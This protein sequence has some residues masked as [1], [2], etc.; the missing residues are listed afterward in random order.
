[1]SFVSYGLDRV[2][3]KR[4][5]FDF[6]CGPLRFESTI[7]TG[8][9]DEELRCFLRGFAEPTFRKMVRGGWKVSVQETW[10]RHDVKVN[11]R[12]SHGL[13]YLFL[14][15]PGGRIVVLEFRY[16]PLPESVVAE[17]R[18][19]ADGISENDDDDRQQRHESVS[20]EEGSAD[21]G[22]GGGVDVEEH[23]GSSG[24]RGTGDGEQEFP[25]R[26]AD[27]S[28]RRG[29]RRLLEVGRTVGEESLTP[30]EVSA[31]AENLNDLRRG[32]N[33]LSGEAR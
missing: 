10:R 5:G 3:E 30:S 33:P 24:E 28:G 17:L 11:W 27:R 19:Y 23:E 8:L 1:M 7:D 21:A 4:G 29:E 2:T 25:R 20:A 22:R 32:K 12:G 6:A 15:R 13:R 26:E 14:T 31:L 9:H 16:Q 18:L